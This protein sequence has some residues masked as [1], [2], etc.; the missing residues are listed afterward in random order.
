MRASPLPNMS[1]MPHVGSMLTSI[2][3]KR[4][5]AIASVARKLGRSA[6]GVAAYRRRPSLQL[7]IVYELCHA[8]QHNLLLDIAA[9]LPATFSNNIPKD[10]S[11]DEQIQALQN[12]LLATQQQ[13]KGAILE[14]DILLK[15][16]DKR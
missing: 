15:V 3:K 11:K 4:N 5:M 12:Q 6:V 10:T 1:A 14:R 16:L 9:T 13:L 7:S 8:L 2:S